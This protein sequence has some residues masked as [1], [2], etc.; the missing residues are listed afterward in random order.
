MPTSNPST[1]VKADLLDAGRDELHGD[2]GC[3]QAWQL[4][5]G[6]GST[7]GTVGSA[8]ETAYDDI[9]VGD[10]IRIDQHVADPNLPSPLLQ[11]IQTTPHRVG[12][13]DRVGEPAERRRRHH[14]R[15]ARPRRSRRRRRP[16]HGRRRRAGRPGLRR[17][18]LLDRSPASSRMRRTATWRTAS[19]RAAA[20]R[21]SAARSSTAAPD[22]AACDFTS[23]ADNSG[24]LLVDNQPRDYR[25]PDT[26][27]WWAEYLIDYAAWHSFA[28]DDGPS[29]AGS[30]GNDYLAG[31]A[32]HDLVFGQLGQR[33]HPGRRRHRVGATRPRT[34]SAPHA[35]PTAAHALDPADRP[36]A[37]R[38]VRPRRRSRPDPVVRRAPPTARTT[39]RAAAATTSSSAASARTTSSAAAPT[40]SA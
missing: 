1:F 31:G 19:S 28:F 8:P 4:A 3:P 11:R 25:D 12:A 39:S 36:D 32:H 2:G 7:S 29:G 5:N 23:L 10:H 20:S 38:H 40:S 15:R 26:A 6:C 22:V 13:S 34:T 35:P 16:R 17:Q 9:I 27:P 18:R 33:H 21:R 30:W 24:A 14:L 37:R